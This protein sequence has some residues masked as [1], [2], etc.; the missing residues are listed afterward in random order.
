VF[1]FRSDR[2]LAFVDR[3]GGDSTTPNA[4]VGSG[5]ATHLQ[6]SPGRID[7]TSDAWTSSRKPLAGEFAYH[8]RT[9]FVVANHF[10]SK[11][12]DDAIMGHNQPPNFPSE[13]QRHKQA[14]EVHDFVASITDADPNADVV[15]AGDL[16]DFQFSQTLDILRGGGLLHDLIDT[17][18]TNE[19]YTYDFEGN[20][21][22]LDHILVSGDLFTRPFDYDV[23]HVNAEFADQASDHDPQV[24]RLTGNRAPTVS[25]G[26]PYTVD[27]GGSAA[28][29]ATGDDP[30]GDALAYAWDLDGDGTFETTGRTATLDAPDGPATR[31]VAVRVTDPAGETADD[32]ATVTIDNVAPTATF[33]AP[34]QVFAGQAFT[35]ALDDPRDPSAGD[36]TAGF[37]YAFDCGDGAG[38]GAYSAASTATCP[39]S[40]VGTR[41]VGGRIRDRDGGVTEYHATVRV[42]ATYDSVCALAKQYQERAHGAADA[43]CAAL[44]IAK[45]EAAAG[46]HAAARAALAVAKAAVRAGQFTRDYTDAEATTLIR[47]IDSLPS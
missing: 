24:V 30:D 42:T 12:G 20:S 13:V 36:T 46:H 11:G 22:V 41:A 23:V 29:T 45:R 3:P 43:V 40:A 31:T 27:E 37:T 14:T 18:P 28:L 38:F 10:N 17:L 2:G 35:P 39:T 47:L 19:Q 33:S 6:Y 44:A 9:L 1:L 15:V 5:D 32:T 7:P 25:A 8:G 34:G 21:E 26:G 4:V 16:N